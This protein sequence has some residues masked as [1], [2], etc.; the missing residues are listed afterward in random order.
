MRTQIAQ[1]ISEEMKFFNRKLFDR[2]RKGVVSG[3]SHGPN[4]ERNLSL[5]QSSSGL[6]LLNSS[7]NIDPL[8]DST[9][10]EHTLKP[11]DENYIPGGK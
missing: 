9:I 8:Q 5:T 2:Q 1:D 7:A 10:K 6:M 3:P 11:G 4:G